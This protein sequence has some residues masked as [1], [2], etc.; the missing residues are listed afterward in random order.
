MVNDKSKK[1]IFLLDGIGAGVSV[2]E[3]D[4]VYKRNNYYSPVNLQQC[5]CKCFPYLR[6]TSS[7]SDF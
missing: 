3:G 6:Y 5:L 2:T 7:L 1:A 4:T